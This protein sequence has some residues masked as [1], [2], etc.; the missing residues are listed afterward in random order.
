M[1]TF[2]SA[3]GSSD[4]DGNTLNNN[5]EINLTDN[6][7][8]EVNNFS[9]IDLDQLPA[10][11]QHQHSSYV[12]LTEAA[13]RQTDSNS[14]SQD[15]PSNVMRS[16]SS[17]PVDRRISMPD[18]SK[19]SASSAAAVAAVGPTIDKLKQWGRSTYKCT[20]QTIFEKLGK[21]TRTVDVELDTQIEVR[22]TYSNKNLTF[23]LLAT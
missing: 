1:T 19:I 8:Q 7:Q 6:H 2:A 5:S 10:S 16:T 18:M 21:T 11:P 15:P 13:T 20:K 9:S 12:S 4:H 23:F 3:F 14:S 17:I 22:K